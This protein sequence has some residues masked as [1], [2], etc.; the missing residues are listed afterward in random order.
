MSSQPILSSLSLS[1]G[2]SRANSGDANTGFSPQRLTTRWYGSPHHGAEGGRDAAQRKL[3]R[4][5]ARIVVT[6]LLMSRPPARGAGPPRSIA[7]RPGTAQPPTA[8]K[9]GQRPSPG[10]TAATVPSRPSASGWSSSREPPC[11]TRDDRTRRERERAAESRLLQTSRL[12]G[13]RVF[14]RGGVPS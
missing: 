5:R 12:G 9:V 11:G 13:H 14:L 7:G 10:R 1:L 4:G 2:A 3:R 8:N 6:G